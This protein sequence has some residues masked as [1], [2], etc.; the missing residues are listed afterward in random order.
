VPPDAIL[1]YQKSVQ[2]LLRGASIDRT[3]VEYYHQLLRD[4]GTPSTQISPLGFPLL[5]TNLAT[6][7]LR[8]GKNQEAYDAAIHARLLNPNLVEPYILMSQAL[9]PQGLKE[10]AAQALVEGILVSGEEGLLAPLA[11]L[12]KY[13][14][15]PDA[16][17]ITRTAN[18]PFLNNRCAK[19][20]AE[21]C[22]GSAELI[23]LYRENLRPDLEALAKSKAVG[24][25][26]C[27]EA[28]L[29]KH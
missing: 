27:K 1:A 19:V 16:C 17:A 26:D 4:R 10:A 2:I 8:L 7:Y 25:F 3:Q 11:V 24:Q 5:Y 23:R 6:A 28:Q 12:Y 21:I 9:A 13:G 14:V 15:D 22:S 20:H 29:E 18:G